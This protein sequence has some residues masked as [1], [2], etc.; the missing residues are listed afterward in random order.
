MTKLTCRGSDLGSH[1]M[2]TRIAVR[3]RLHLDDSSDFASRATALFFSSPGV[4]AWVRSS[5]I[6]P[7]PFRG[8][9][10]FGEGGS[11]REEGR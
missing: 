9:S 5:P 8:L 7:V 1:N 11:Q 10:R 2:A 4:H 3:A 6:F